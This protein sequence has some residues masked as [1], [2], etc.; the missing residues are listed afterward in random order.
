M[1]GL[2][3]LMF[4][5]GSAR[6]ENLEHLRVAKWKATT[7]RV[8]ICDGLEIDTDIVVRAID[9]W[10]V[11]GEK[12]GKIIRKECSEDPLRGEI[13]LFLGNHLPDNHAGEAFRFIKEDSQTSM[14]PEITRAGIFIQ[15]RYSDSVLL[16][17]H[18]LGHALGYTDTDDPDSI[19]V[20]VGPIY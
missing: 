1:H 6:G 3:G 2:L 12:I 10:R 8:V 16:V 18:E 19:M 5:V 14:M 17:Q 20:K 15:S 13:A 11:R 4:L 7:P 9:Y